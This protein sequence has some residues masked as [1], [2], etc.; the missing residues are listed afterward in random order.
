MHRDQFPDRV[1]L[2]CRRGRSGVGVGPGS[3]SLPVGQDMLGDMLDGR[4]HRGG[5]RGV[6]DEDNSHGIIAQ[7][8]DPIHYVA[9]DGQGRDEFCADVPGVGVD[10]RGADREPYVLKYDLDSLLIPALLVSEGRPPLHARRPVAGSLDGGEDARERRERLAG[11]EREFSSTPGR[12]NCT[13]RRRGSRVSRPF[14]GRCTRRGSG[15]CG[16]ARRRLLR[17][18]GVFRPYPSPEGIEQMRQGSS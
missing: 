17:G 6:N 15:R 7:L 14:C 13:R 2:S 8:V 3:A 1:T 9:V 16:T 4:Y 10:P 11:G 12:T 18:A 5:V